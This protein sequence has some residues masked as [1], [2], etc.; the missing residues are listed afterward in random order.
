ML[1]SKPTSDE[2]K[3]LSDCEEVISF[4]KIAL[5]IQYK[6]YGRVNISDF[7][8]RGGFSSRSYI[9]ELLA[10][11]KG[12]SRDAILRIRSALKFPKPVLDVFEL[13]AYRSA[14][15]LRPTTLSVTALDEKLRAARA[16]ARGL[17]QSRTLGKAKSTFIRDFR[18]YQIYAALGT[19]EHG[20]SIQEIIARTNMA[21]KMADSCLQLLISE[22]VIEYRE[23]RYYAVATK[24][25]YFGLKSSDGLGNLISEVCQNIKSRR[26]EL[27]DDPLNALFFTAFSTSSNRLPEL[28]T[29]LKDAIFNVLDEYQVD[30]G[31]CVRQL[32]FSLYL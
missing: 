8:K 14:P 4:L 22:G 1:T 30:D 15:A 32:L 23:G 20:A 18:L 28:R 19:L 25:D 10:E 24:M 26:H 29:K 11:K 13:L 2:I 31:D 17:S 12:L 9:S 27:I 6:K 5:E 16:A 7:S 3:L 21:E